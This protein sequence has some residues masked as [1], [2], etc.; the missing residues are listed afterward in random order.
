MI[1]KPDESTAI[2]I[3]RAWDSFGKAPAAS[4]AR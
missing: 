2:S 4:A 3:G 1:F